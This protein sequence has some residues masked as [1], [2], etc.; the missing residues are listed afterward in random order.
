M[1]PHLIEIDDELMAFLR[2]KI[3]DFDDTPNSVLRRELRIS[4]EPS[5]T[6][7]RGRP[8]REVPSGDWTVPAALAQVIEVVRL[9]RGNGYDRNSATNQVAR[10][11]RISRESVADKYGRQ[12]GLSTEQFDRMLAAKDLKE[13]QSRLCTRFPGNT[14][15]IEHFFRSL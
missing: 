7:R 1:S 8:P 14:D 6:S 15:F 10:N 3:H 13:L 4:D 11:R 2:S 5:A 9:V 12:L